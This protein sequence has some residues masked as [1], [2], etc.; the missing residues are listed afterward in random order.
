VDVFHH[1]GG[2]VHQDTHGQRQSTQGH[3]VDGLPGAPQGHHGGQQG[4]GDGG[5]DNQR[6]A[7]IPQEQ[8]HD[9]ARQQSTQQ[10][11]AHNGI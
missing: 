9:E 5:H 2:L 8:E 1:D 11:F 10:S 3:D 4:E 7:P 6:A